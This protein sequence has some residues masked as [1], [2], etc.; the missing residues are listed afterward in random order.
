MEG[1]RIVSDEL[2]VMKV[3]RPDY[4]GAPIA[5]RTRVF[6]NDFEI[7]GLIK[8]DAQ[9]LLGGTLLVTLTVEVSRAEIEQ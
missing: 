6:L 7:P 2:P 8:M 5:W 4:S 9:T 3:I 1:D